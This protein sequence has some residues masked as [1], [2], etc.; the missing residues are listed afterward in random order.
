MTGNDQ[1]T[2]IIRTKF[3]RPPEPEDIVCRQAALADVMNT[4]CVLSVDCLEQG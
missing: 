2:P 4:L 1:L 3:Y